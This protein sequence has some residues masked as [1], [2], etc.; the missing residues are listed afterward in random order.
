MTERL[1]HL[2]NFVSK[3]SAS[4]ASPCSWQWFVDPRLRRFRELHRQVQGLHIVS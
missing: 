3:V 2:L 4:L 1:G